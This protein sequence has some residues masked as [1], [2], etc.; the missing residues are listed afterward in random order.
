MK[1]IKFIALGVFALLVGCEDAT[2]IVQPGEFLEPAAFQNVDDLQAGIFG[3]Y[4]SLDNSAVIS[5]TS[6]FTDE[7]SIGRA[8]GG[9]GVTNDAVHLYN[10]TPNTGAISGIWYNTYSFINRA[11]RLLAAADAITPEMG[12]ED[13]YNQV[14]AEALAMRAFGH[15]QL[16]TFY[17]EDLTD[18]S[19]T[20][21]VNVDFVPEL[22]A[23]LPRNTVG[24][25][26]TFIYDDLNQAES[27][28]LGLNS[29]VMNPSRI[30][31]NEDFV[32][33][34]RGRV[35]LYTEN[36]PVA[37]DMADLLLADYSVSS[38]TNFPAVWA[39]QST[40]GI[41]FKAERVD[42]NGAIGGVW[43]TN[44]STAGGA[45]V[46]ELSREVFNTLDNN[47]NDVRRT[48]YV[49]PTSVISPTYMTDVNPRFTDILVIDKY[50]GDP[51][52]SSVLINDLKIFRAAE[53][54][55]VKA[56][57]R[58]NDM[59]LTGAANEIKAIR[60]NRY[61]SPAALP[62]YANAQEA[63]ADVLAERRLELYLEGHRYI[64]VSRLASK[65]GV[66]GYDRDD[67]DC[68]I[69][70]LANCDLSVT[71]TIAQYWPI[72][73]NEVSATNNVVTQNDG[74]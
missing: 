47:P 16:M 14:R 62:V 60:D 66:T 44:N 9:Q 35:A 40:D 34:L 59:D 29:P 57:A 41:I 21:I 53:F 19:S 71:E 4:S 55:F 17:S 24:E 51:S 54:R 3:V 33:A 49:D 18:P 10:L 48:T 70:G 58:I 46:Y 72:P 28:F 31:I 68:S 73:Q 13:A 45:P 25:N 5:F 22:G 15:A 11:N 74:Y 38:R 12:E 63:W 69:A 32:R 37:E 65:A 30:F 8:N 26:L 43:N 6:I 56:E 39:D 42:G 23:V 64:D 52:L 1:K 27:L 67:T 2:D 36:Y 50:P 7:V 20:G 61:G